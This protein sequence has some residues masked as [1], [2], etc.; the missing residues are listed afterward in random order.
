MADRDEALP[1]LPADWIDTL[2][3]V[4]QPPAVVTRAVDRAVADAVET[5]FAERRARPAWR[6]PGGWASLAAS[7]ALATVVAV[8][9]DREDGALYADVDASG[10]V[11]IAD[12]L[13]LARTGTVGPRELDAFAQRIVAL[14]GD[15]GR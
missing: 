5:R 7:I 14:D 10:R 6:H 8:R 3:R 2:N 11:D 13:A 15:A 12:V 1:D 4:D 9:W